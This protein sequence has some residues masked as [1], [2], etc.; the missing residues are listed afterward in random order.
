MP[1]TKLLLFHK[2]VEMIER[3]QENPSESVKE[4]LDSK[5]SYL[6][7]GYITSALAVQKQPSRG[8]LRKWC[9][10]N[11]QQIY[12]RTPMR[13]CDFNKVAINVYL[14]I[15]LGFHVMYRTRGF[16]HQ[17]QALNITENLSSLKL[18]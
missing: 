18:S 6:P 11:M 8:V 10:E 14:S 4:N 2:R 3:I 17:K 12:R 1:Q 13:K 7:F 9:F 16:P 15:L 5:N